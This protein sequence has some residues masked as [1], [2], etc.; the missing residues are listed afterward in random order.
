[1]GKRRKKGREG[2]RWA[3][4]PGFPSEVKWLVERRVKE[5]EKGRRCG[6]GGRYKRFSPRQQS[7]AA[8][9]FWYSYSWRERQRG[10]TE[11]AATETLNIE[12]ETAKTTLRP[13]FG[14][15]RGG[16]GTGALQ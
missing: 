5:G 7:L 11:K 3:T 16:A 1:M 6:G 10:N 9:K 15:V 14:G 13:L 4:F 8:H 12:P 2:L